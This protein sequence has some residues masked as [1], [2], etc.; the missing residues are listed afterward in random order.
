MTTSA[1][2]HPFAKPAKDAGEF[3]TLVRGEGSTLWDRDGK[4]YI[5][6]MASLWYCN[7]GHG[8][9]RIIEAVK[10]QL[11]SL[12]TYNTFDPWTNE[13]AEAL[14][15]RIADVAPMEHPRVFFTCSGSESVDTALKLA[16]LTH[17]R[18]GDGKRQL[19]V[20]R[21]G[22]Y[23]GTA[24][25]GTSVQGIPANKE[26]WGELVPGTL[27]VPQNDIEAASRL[28]A[29]RG[30]EIAAVIAEPVQGAG[31]VFPPAP[32]YLEGLRRLCD[33]H[34]A[35]LIFDEVICGWGRLG[36]W[37]GAQHYGVTPDLITFAK[38]VTSGYVP[39]GG[40]IA[41]RK[42]CDV[43]ESDPELLLRHGYTYSGHPTSCA[44]GLATLAV[45]E[46]D[47]LFERAAVIGK[48][49]G[50]GLQSL[51]DDGVIAGVRGVAGVWA[52]ELDP[53]VDAYAVRDRMLAEGVIARP[54]TNAMAFCP[55]LV[56]T[57]AEIG[58]MVD[59]LATALR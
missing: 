16:R 18:L 54:L 23:H 17:N 14:A 11:D 15:A 39:L 32:D 30:E 46:E 12:A 34:G 3:I 5:D 56:I 35:L 49:L 2:L 41:S 25:G 26:G 19:L 1:F 36:H 13:P 31:G 20:S 51:A 33:Q 6:G 27:N 7:A 24:Y 8:E 58:R 37:F 10:K 55:P 52:A 43:L 45:Y 21:G 4:A 44:A 40:V 22:G 9:R 28:F 50:D 48:L 42:V 59:A 53:T 38:G 47:N 29:E 57:E